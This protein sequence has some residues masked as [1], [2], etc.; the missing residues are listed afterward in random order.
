[1][2][3]TYGTWNGINLPVWI[4]D[5]SMLTFREENCKK[6]FAQTASQKDDGFMVSLSKVPVP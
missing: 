2:L 4:S 5:P 6:T 3:G 1:M